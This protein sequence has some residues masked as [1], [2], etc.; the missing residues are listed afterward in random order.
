MSPRT[1]A[2]KSASIAACVLASALLVAC[3]GRGRAS[4]EPMMADPAG[5]A[6]DSEASGDTAS[7]DAKSDA[8]GPPASDPSDP[9]SGAAILQ[10]NEDGARALL[11]QFVAADADH[12]A[13]T[14]SLRPTTSD[15]KTLFDAKAAAKIEAAQAKDW[16]SNKAVIKPKAGQTEIKVWGATGS[17]LAKGTGNAREFPGGYKKVAKHLSPTVLFFRFKFVEAGKDTGTAYD[18]LAF[19]NGHWVIAPKPWRAME[20]KTG[21]MEDDAEAPAEKPAAKKKP[22]AGKKKK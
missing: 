6:A 4:K 12:H 10:G 16:D 7:T 2:R 22:K 19:I 1:C 15:Y 17:D 20:G 13:L 9:P 5:A 18:G 21:G 11:E 14:R 3:G 8:D